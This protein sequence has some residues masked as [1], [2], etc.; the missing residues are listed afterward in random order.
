MVENNDLDGMA[1]MNL[2]NSCCFLLEER[3]KYLML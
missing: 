1:Y 2:K 3:L